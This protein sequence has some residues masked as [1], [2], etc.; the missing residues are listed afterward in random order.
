MVA[1]HAQLPNGSACGEIPRIP[2]IKPSGGQTMVNAKLGAPSISKTF[3][4]AH[5]WAVQSLTGNIPIFIAA[6]SFCIIQKK[7][8]GQ[9]VVVSRERREI[10]LQRKLLWVGIEAISWAE[11]LGRAAL[12]K[13]GRTPR[14]PT[15]PP[16]RV[17]S[18]HICP[19]R[20]GSM[21]RPP[22]GRP[23]TA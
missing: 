9:P 4:T 5:F 12:R 13:E 1:P 6:I 8:R 23:R 15:S 21:R 22:L 3:E 10:A 11:P 20:S 14:P 7:R 19:R 16:Q 2:K 17:P 18:P